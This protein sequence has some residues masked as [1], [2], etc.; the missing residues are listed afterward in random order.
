MKPYKKRARAHGCWGKDYKEQKN[1]SERNYAKKE[2]SQ[3]EQ[4]HLEGDDFRYSF[5]SRS[6]IPKRDRKIAWYE[7]TIE[8][9]EQSKHYYKH[10]C[11]SWYGRTLMSFKDK[12]KKLKKER[13]DE[14]G[15]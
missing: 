13:E 4:E 7:K 5:Y 3:A 8:A 11:S 10:N 15:N 9:W 2:I 14:Q 12:L 1:R 6:R